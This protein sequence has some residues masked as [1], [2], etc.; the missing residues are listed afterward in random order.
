MTRR[1]GLLREEDNVSAAI[2][3]P[4]AITIV[5]YW[6]F[7]GSYLANNVLGVALCIM[8]GALCRVQSFR[9]LVVLMCGLFAYDVFFVFFSDKFFSKNVMV[10]V[11]TN[12][13]TNPVNT[14][15]SWLHLPVAPVKDLSMPAKLIF[16]SPDGSYSILGLGDI[17]LPLLLLI[18][19]VKLD[20]TLDFPLWKGFFAHALIAHIAALFVS[21]YCNAVFQAA[22]PALFYIVPLTLGVTTFLAN[23]NH[24]LTAMWNDT[25]SSL[26]RYRQL[27]NASPE[28]LEAVIGA[29]N[30]D[31][32]SP[33]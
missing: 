33:V 5:G 27:Q 18:Y 10:E 9:S 14:I 32:V 25:I 7:T 8:F 24:V 4:I 16:P 26:P 28:E 29:K 30:D 12:S 31:E 15:A 1:I 17:V 13:S 11:A 21:F 19:L 3:S 23:R 6:L 22:Q 20:L 2:V